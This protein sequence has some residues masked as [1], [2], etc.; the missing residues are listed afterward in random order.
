MT[1]FVLVSS[2]RERIAEILSPHPVAL[3]YLYGSAAAGRA[4]PLSDVDIALVLADNRTAIPNQL[5]FELALEAEIA[6]RC[7]IHNADV[8]IING[9]PVTFRGQVVSEGILLFARDEERRIEFETHTLSEYFDFLPVDKFLRDAYFDH[10]REKG[11][12]GERS[13]N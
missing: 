3:A 1:T 13:K 2:L 9:A 8:R 10:L 7:G 6:E 11:L 12:Y 5:E 4:T